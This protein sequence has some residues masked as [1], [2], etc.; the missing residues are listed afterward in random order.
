MKLVYISYYVHGATADNEK[1]AASG[2]HDCPLSGLG[3]KQS[4]ELRNLIKGKK[5]DAVFCSDLKRAVESARLCFG[6]SARIIQD[7]RLREINYGDFT[8]A[9]SKKVDSIILKHITEP[10]SHG[11]SYRDVERRM[12]SFLDDL[13]KKYPGKGVAAVSHRAPQ[14]ALDVILRGRSWEQAV[15]E[16]WRPR[17]AWQPGWEYKLEG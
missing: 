6:D 3:R 7:E 12:R 9:D 16:D 1:G 14:L 10:F 4:L 17:K 8:Q 15:K 13:L 2:W 5:F 11:E